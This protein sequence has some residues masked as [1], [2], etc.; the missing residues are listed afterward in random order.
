M[1]IDS[2]KRVVLFVVFILAQATVFGHIHLFGVATPLLYVWFVA[3]FPT[4]YP[5][6]AVLLWS[7]FLGLAVDIFSNTPGAAA[8]SLTLLGLLQPLL[9]WLFVPRNAADNLVP[10]F[11]TLGV[12]F[13]YYTTMLVLIYCLVF[14]SLETFSYFDLARWSLCV[15]GSA[16]FT[17]VLILTVESVS[18]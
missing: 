3:K 12:K 2:I 6:W 18:Q 14:F 10:S 13:I 16:V 8:G 4:G 15:V 9:L 17:L 1:S 11:H 5:K 7:F